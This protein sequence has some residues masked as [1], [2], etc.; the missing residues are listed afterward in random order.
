MNKRYHMQCILR[1]ILGCL[2]CKKYQYK[3]KLIQQ[4][5]PQQHYNTLKI[6]KTILHKHNNIDVICVTEAFS[7]ICTFLKFFWS[8]FNSAGRENNSSVLWSISN[9]FRKYGVEHIMFRNSI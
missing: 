5:K 7:R 3:Y 9:I 2:A 4:C 8:L 1:K 6:K